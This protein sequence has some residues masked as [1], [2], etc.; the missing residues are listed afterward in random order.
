[1]EQQIQRGQEWLAKLLALMKIPSQVKVTEP[2]SGSQQS[3]AAWL[4]I[5]ESQLNPEQ[6]QLLIGENGKTIDAIQYLASALV[7]IGIA[8]EEQRAF[9]VE[10]NGYRLRRQAELKQLATE[11]A[12]Q[13]RSTGQEAEIRHLSA[14]ERRQVHTFL[15]DAEDLATESRGQ[16]PDRRLVVRRR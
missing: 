7:N 1:M 14:A 10:L 9:T 2:E 12:E 6:I 4:T 13:V 11:I 16:E 15:Q 3:T 8:P 5:D